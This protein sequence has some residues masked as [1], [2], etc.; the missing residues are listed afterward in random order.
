MVL[1]S[2]W[3]Q[4]GLV[5]AAAMLTRAT[6]ASRGRDGSGKVRG[7]GL[8]SPKALQIRKEEI[9]GRIRRR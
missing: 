6:A 2:G 4:I 9:E 8:Y 3:R 7:L 5:L 1:S